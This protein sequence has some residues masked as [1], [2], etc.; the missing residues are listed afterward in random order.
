MPRGALGRCDC[1]L[2]PRRAH[3]SA[4]HDP[5]P[6]GVQE[7]DRPRCVQQGRGLGSELLSP[8]LRIVLVERSERLDTGMFQSFELEGES[9]RPIHQSSHAICKRVC[10]SRVNRQI[11]CALSQQAA[12]T[13]FEVRTQFP[14]LRCLQRLLIIRA[15]PADQCDRRQCIVVASHR[16]SGK[17]SLLVEVALRNPPGPAAWRA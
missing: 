15:Q 14:I 17:L 2:S 16:P 4:A 10:N 9:R 7:L 6:C 1:D 12:R 11:S 8:V 5:E 3:V 13:S